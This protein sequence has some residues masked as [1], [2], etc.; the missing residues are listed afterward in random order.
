MLLCFS[1]GMGYRSKFSGIIWK[2]CLPRSLAKPPH[3][4]SQKQDQH[5]LCETVILQTPF[6]TTSLPFPKPPWK[7]NRRLLR[8]FLKT[9]YFSL[10]FPPGPPTYLFPHF[11]SPQQH[12]C[13]TFLLFSEHSWAGMKQNN[14]YY[15]VSSQGMGPTLIPTVKMT[16]AS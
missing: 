7:Q 13:L 1:Q 6:H 14:I 3:E 16:E 12:V 4:L 2:W 5:P 9:E 11:W 10:S 15:S 8:F